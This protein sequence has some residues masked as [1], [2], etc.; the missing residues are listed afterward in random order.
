MISLKAYTNWINKTNGGERI[1]Y[2]RGYLCDPALQPISPNVDIERV[3]KLRRLV[4]KSQEGNL[5]N[6]LQKRHGDFDYEY[7]AFRR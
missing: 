6:L 5:V 2:Y 7:M 3:K 1:T 4:Q